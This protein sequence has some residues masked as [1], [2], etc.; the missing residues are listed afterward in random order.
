M[1]AGTAVIAKDL[2]ANEV[3]EIKMA[4]VDYVEGFYNA[5][6]VKLKRS[7][8]PALM[9]RSVSLDLLTYEKLA[10]LSMRQSWG[11]PRSI[12]VE[13]YDISGIIAAAKIR[14]SFINYVHLLKVDGKWQILD[15]LWDYPKD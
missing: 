8:H 3:N 9:K 4:C 1:F 7:V 12:T 15:V 11:K 6:M 5:D 2:P 14:S 10:E 13:V